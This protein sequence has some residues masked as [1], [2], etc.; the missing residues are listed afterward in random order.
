[1]HAGYAPVA[2][3]PALPHHMHHS[4]QSSY[5]KVCRNS[6]MRYH[7]SSSAVAEKPRCRVVS[8][9]WAVG[10]VVG[11]TILCTKPFRCQTKSSAK[12]DR[13]ACLYCKQCGRAVKNDKTNN[14]GTKVKVPQSESSRQRI[15]YGRIGTFIREGIGVGAKTAYGKRPPATPEVSLGLGLGLG[16]RL[17][18]GLAE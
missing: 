3:A 12:A 14:I 15:G 11:Q 18:L 9:G 1:M 4:I 10:D 17:A 13:T 16:L 8:F 7:K 6:N 2:C 5:Y